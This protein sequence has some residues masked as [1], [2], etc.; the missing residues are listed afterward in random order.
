[1]RR[2]PRRATEPLRTVVDIALSLD[3]EE[4]TAGGHP[5]FVS[6]G[7]YEELLRVT[8]GNASEIGG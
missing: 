2:C 3:D 8:C 5:H 7:N 1:M 4:W 6:P